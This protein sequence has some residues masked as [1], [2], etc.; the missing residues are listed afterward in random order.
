MTL[1]DIELGNDSLHCMTNLTACCQQPDTGK[2]S[3]VS[4]NWFFPNKTRVPS[5]GTNWDFYRARPGM[6][7]H[8]NRREG[9]VEGI[10]RC[11][12]NDSIN[13]LQTIYIGVYNA[14]T[15]KLLSNS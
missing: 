11:E 3:S 1:E 9:G 10:Y 14:N 15:G 5:K 7:V 12:I 2:N 13:V 8:L 4:S 6:V